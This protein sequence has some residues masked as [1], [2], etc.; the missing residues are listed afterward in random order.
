MKRLVYIL[1][2]CLCLTACQKCKKKQI[3]AEGYLI[4]EQTGHHINPFNDA[5]VRLFDNSGG[6]SIEVGNSKVDENGYYIINAQYKTN[7]DGKLQLTATGF[8]S[9][10]ATTLSS[11]M[12]NDFIIS[13]SSTLNRL[14]INQSTTN[15]DSILVTIS[16]SQGVTKYKDY[17]FGSNVNLRYPIRGNENNYLSSYLYAN[18][19]FTQR[20]DTIYAVCRTTVQDTLRY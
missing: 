4:E 7:L 17:L 11:K 20:F 14:F 19:L 16:N 18:G 2:V 15:F 1:F 9:V 3:V 8:T 10:L 5:I 12:N 13:C 6:S